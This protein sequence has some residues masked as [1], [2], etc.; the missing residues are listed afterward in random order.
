MIRLVTEPADWVSS[1]VLVDKANVDIRIPLDPK[2]LNQ[3]IKWQ[4]HYTQKLSGILPRLSNAR[5]SNA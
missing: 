5:A 2:D 1:I 4:Q 3:A